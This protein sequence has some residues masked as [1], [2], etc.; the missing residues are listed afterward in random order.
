[1]KLKLKL[2]QP[3]ITLRQRSKDEVVHK[4]LLWGNQGMEG[5]ADVDPTELVWTSC[6]MTQTW[7]RGDGEHKQMVW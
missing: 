4:V 3:F 6:W 1:M 5:K 2:M 7:I